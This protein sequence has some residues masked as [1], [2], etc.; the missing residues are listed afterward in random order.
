MFDVTGA[1]DTVVATMS[2][3]LAA[4]A[5]FEA[6]ARLRSFTAAA[7]ELSITHSAVRV[8][9][10][11]IR[12]LQSGDAASAAISP[13]N[14]VLRA[15]DIGRTHSC[16]NAAWRAKGMQAIVMQSTCSP[17]SLRTRL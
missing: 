7:D 16:R 2:L 8:I 6:A 11:F 9:S 4:G 13:R 14:P 12:R 3:A 17:T 10:G 1:G 15:R 5:G